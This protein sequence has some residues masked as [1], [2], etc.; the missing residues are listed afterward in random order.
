MYRTMYHVHG[1][2]DRLRWC[3]Q[4]GPP[5]QCG[6]NSKLTAVRMR[7]KVLAT[8]GTVAA[9]EAVCEHVPRSS[10]LEEAQQLVDAALARNAELRAVLDSGCG[11]AG[12]S[13]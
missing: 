3:G 1:Q 5:P 2:W 4:R 8:G 6:R 7:P 10:F 9:E 11:F 13:P 12:H